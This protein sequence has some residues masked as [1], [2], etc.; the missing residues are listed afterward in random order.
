MSILFSLLMMICSVPTYA[1]SQEED[2]TKKELQELY[3]LSLSELMEIK[4]SSPATLTQSNERYTPAAIT[5]INHEDIKGSGARTLN[6]LLQIYVPGLQLARHHYGASHI[7]TRGIISGQDNY[8]ITVNGRAINKRS[9]TGAIAER[10]LM[11]LADI[12]QIEVIR[13]PGSAVY[14]FGAESMVIAITTFDGNT[15]DGTEIRG[16][17]GLGT[18]RVSLEAKHGSTFGKQGAFF[19]YG[20]ISHVP[21][22]SEENSPYIFGTSFTAKDSTFVEAGEP[23]PT[24]I[25]RDGAA[26][27]DLPPMKLH[28]QLDLA[29]FNANV[30][31]TSGGDQL[32]NRITRVATP[33]IGNSSELTDQV[34]QV[35]YHQLGID[36]DYKWDINDSWRLEFGA[37]YDMTDYERLSLVISNLDQRQMSHR[38]D[39]YFARALAHWNPN[40]QFSLAVGYVYNHNE[41][42]LE[43]PGFPNQPPSSGQHKDGMPRWST[44]IH[45]PLA[46]AQ[47]HINDVWATFL[48]ARVDKHS[49]SDFEI[50][51]RFALVVTPTK[52][53]GIKLILSRSNL[54]IYADNAYIDYQDGSENIDT[55]TLDN[56]EL[57]YERNQSSKLFTALSIY[58]QNIHAVGWDVEQGKSTIV[59]EQTQAGG[60]WEMSYRGERFQIGL[61]HQYHK[62]IE[63]KLGE[64]A[65][66]TF[67]TA[68]PFGFGND[69]DSWSNNISKI[70]L[71]HTLSDKWRIHGNLQYL[72]W[73]QGMKDQIDYRNSLV[74]DD[75]RITDPGW[76]DSFEKSVF[77]NMGVAF[78]PI[79]K[80]TINLIG[81][82]LLGL[83]DEDL[84][85]Q[86][87]LGGYGGYR[88]LS[89]S[90]GLD[91]QWE[92]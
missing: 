43:S 56:I 32:D 69:L 89:P 86:N 50:S 58:F 49:F 48:S 7:G 36:V 23:T 44:N 10:D 64:S 73:F 67:V 74:A 45:S 51:P 40:K 8:F 25:S 34:G 70:D 55:E 62:L 52:R 42:G 29:D 19:L 57:R 91:A 59:G 83:F 54:L 13:G 88:N 65:K 37:G 2:S 90:I 77:L 46:E 63:F 14:G 3:Q 4:V 53:D 68:A 11:L 16:R 81:Y 78:K 9:E 15:F 60:E 87:Y 92:F 1:M 12:K 20:G 17:A 80:L 31:Y 38:E 85:K 71:S 72:W 66:S 22:A 84:N 33:P 41:Y 79:N 28:A 76:D 18:N 27:R 75:A 21:G 5:V 24:L 35:G 61:S 47:W 26:Y 39:G 6:E 82:H 30:R